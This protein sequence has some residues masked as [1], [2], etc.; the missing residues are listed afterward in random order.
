MPDASRRVRVLPLSEYDAVLQ[1]LSKKRRSVFISSS[2]PAR[3]VRGPS[4]K[5][6]E[7]DFSFAV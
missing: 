3:M 6:R 1:M 7:R 2:V 4:A 5:V